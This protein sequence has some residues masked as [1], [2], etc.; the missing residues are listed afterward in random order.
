M[1]G[2][3]FLLLLV[4]CFGFPLSVNADLPTT[5]VCH[6]QFV[7]NPGDPP[8]DDDEYIPPSNPPTRKSVRLPFVVSPSD[9]AL[10]LTFT[11][12]LSEVSLCVVDS[13]TQEVVYSS[14]EYVPSSIT[15]FINTLPPSNYVLYVL[16]PD[17]GEYEYEFT[18]FI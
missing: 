5:C 7:D 14:V 4:C 12:M 3:I 8:G 18:T 2:T 9:D 17:G 10:V 1:K 6:W 11:T 13:F 16:L 15:L